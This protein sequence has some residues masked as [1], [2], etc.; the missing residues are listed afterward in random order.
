[1]KKTLIL[2]SIITATLLSAQ[3]LSLEGNWSLKGTSSDISIDNLNYA[4]IDTVW[5]YSNNIWN[6]YSPNSAIQAKINSNTTISELSSISKGQGF[7]INANQNCDIEI[8]LGTTT[9]YILSGN[10]WNLLGTGEN[11]DF[12]TLDSESINLVWK[13]QN[14]SWQAYS[15]NTNTANIITSANIDTI[16]NIN[17]GDGFWVHTNDELNITTSTTQAVNG[18]I[19]NYKPESQAKVIIGNDSFLAETN[20]SENGTYSF[21]SVPNGEYFLKLELK[22]YKSQAAKNITVGTM[23]TLNKVLFST[24]NTTDFILEDINSSNF[25]YHWEEDVSRSGHQYT[26]YINTQPKIEFLDEELEVVDLAAAEKLKHD[27]NIILSDDN[28]PWNEEYAYRLLET[29]KTIP[30]ETRDSYKEQSKKISKW[31]LTDDHIAD[32][33]NIVKEDSGDT[34]TISKDAFIYASPKLVLLDGLKGKFFSKKLHHA[35][36]NFVTNHGS[37]LNAVEK[38]LNDRFGCSTIIP[39][40]SSLTQPTTNE[41][42]HS[43]QE[44]HP[45]ELVTIINMFEEMPSG[46]YVVKGLNY[47]VRRKDGMDHPLYDA[48]AVAWPTAHEESYIEFMDTS[49]TADVAHMNRLMIHEKSHFMWANLFSEELKS[50]WYEVGGWYVNEDDPDGWS[51]TK[52]TEFVSAYAHKKNPNEDMAESI[53]YY[54]LN[55][56]MLKSRALGKYEFIRDRIMHGNMYMSQIREDLTFE[57]LNLFP[58]YNYPGKITSVDID[59]VGEPEEDKIITVEIKLHTQDK[60]FDGAKHAYSRVF[61]EIGT[62]NDFYMH[63]VDGNTSILRGS[64]TLSKYAKGGFWFNDQ[65]VITDTVGNQRFEGVDDFGWKMYVDNPL[66]DVVK[67]KYVNNTLQLD[68][69][70]DIVDGHSVQVLNV[71]YEVEENKKMREHYPMYASV[72]NPESGAYRL[73]EY[74]L[75]DENTNRGSIDFYITEYHASGIYEVPYIKFDDA[76]LNQ[77]TQYF[78]D[79]P[80]HQPLVT[81]DVITSNPDLIPPEVDL[82]QI[83][84]S[85]TPANPDAPDGETMVKITYYAKDDKSGLGKVNYRLLDPQGI[86]HFEY[87]YHENFRTLYF[88]GDPTAWTKYE[89]NVVLPAGSAPGIWGLQ[90]LEVYDKAN[91]R[92]SYNFVETMHFEIID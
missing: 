38:I 44:F 13:Y 52:T 20:V 50:D 77:G 30:Q 51:T 78:S 17:S 43:F 75:F 63:P 76:A 81:I 42:E 35:L 86:S 27:Y 39:N 53:S 46:Y 12:S 71:S 22:G 7:W 40:Y 66:E 21:P 60:V 73:E 70:D 91:N 8:D 59:V 3:T 74:G 11:I 57:V 56:D 1:M 25:T 61:S 36:V 6:A 88:E 5:T 10:T 9:N 29:L 55:P 15:P 18:Q 32:D 48:P 69:R 28:K 85:A 24:A 19:N 34:V 45:N 92:E 62:F 54:I 64:F 80:D 67:P 16:T 72:T 37:D 14:N 31:T 2:S 26:A 83:T 68:L 4:C 33:I 23:Q 58:D 90:E 65:I 82:N 87:H 79:S 84:I 41:D 47:L 89:I 49:F